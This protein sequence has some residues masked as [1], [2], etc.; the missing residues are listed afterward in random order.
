MPDGERALVAQ[1]SRVFAGGSPRVRVGLG[2]D[3]AVVQARGR[4]LVVTVDAAVEGTHF[5]R[6]WLSLGDVGRRSFHAA[7]SDLAA[8]GARPLVAVS[9]LVLAGPSP[10]AAARRI[11]QGQA[12]AA[13]ELGCPVVGGNVARGRELS[14]TTT[15]LGEVE[16]P[17][18]RAGARAGDQ[19]W[20]VGRV[21][22]AAAGL[23]LLRRG[24]VPAERAARACVAAWRRPRAAIERGRALVGRA[25][26]CIDVSDGLALDASRLAAASGV[27]LIFDEPSLV[28]ALAPEAVAVAARLGESALAWALGGGED[29]A[30]LA[31]GP[32]RRRPPWAVL[33][34]E[35]TTGRGLALRQRSGRV[36][37]LDPA[38][39]DH[40]SR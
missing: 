9:A 1:L 16:R 30:L 10:A 34:G 35:V 33:V 38:G 24:P 37:R 15:V 23:A 12:A 22:V 5:E 8:M 20:L 28:E 21:G 11:A 14:V 40:L 6:G 17:L 18:L 13:R 27:R 31:A 2:D 19:L 36:R 4:R 29:Y 39:Y 3:A 26:A 32:R 25:R 7:A